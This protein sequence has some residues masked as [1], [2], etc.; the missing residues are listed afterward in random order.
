MLVGTVTSVQATSS[1]TC[2]ALCLSGGANKGAYEAGLLWQL[3]HSDKAEDYYYDVV[4]GVSAGA[5]NA[6]AVAVWPKE[7]SKEMTEWI[8]DLW[9]NLKTSDVY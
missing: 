8:A 2:K 1:N 5:I 3:M 6:A 9:K 7:K 4:T